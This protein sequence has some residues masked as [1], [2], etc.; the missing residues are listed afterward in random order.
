MEVARSLSDQ[1]KGLSGRE[2]LEMGEGM[3]FIFSREEQH[4][5]WMKDMNF[6]IDIIWIGEDSVVRDIEKNVPICEED[7]CPSYSPSAPSRYVL[8]VPAGF[9]EAKSISVGDKVS[10]G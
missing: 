3:F 8:E 4:P 2:G 9:S 5:F 7:P 1:A 10:F 6:P